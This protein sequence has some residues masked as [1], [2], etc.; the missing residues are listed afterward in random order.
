MIFPVILFWM[1]LC[2]GNARSSSKSSWFF[3]GSSYRRYLALL[4]KQLDFDIQNSLTSTPWSGLLS[5][6]WIG[7]FDLN[8]QGTSNSSWLLGG[9]SAVEKWVL[10]F[11]ISIEVHSI[12]VVFAVKSS[13]IGPCSWNT[14]GTSKVPGSSGNFWLWKRTFIHIRAATRRFPHCSTWSNYICEQ[15][16]W[17]YP[18]KILVPQ[19]NSCSIKCFILPE[20]CAVT[21]KILSWVHLG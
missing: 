14:H 18:Q 12:L 5:Y 10:S 1:G 19:G 6:I 9:G 11:E 2:D 17:W 13:S 8:V 20:K 16:L 3:R 7:L 15:S 21:L 4:F